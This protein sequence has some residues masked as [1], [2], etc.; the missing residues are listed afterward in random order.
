MKKNILE[1]F[2]DDNNQLME[3][4]TISTKIMKRL[5][6]F[7]ICSICY[8][9]LTISKNYNTIYTDEVGNTNTTEYINIIML[10][11]YIISAI[12]LIYLILE[13]VIPTK[14]KKITD[15]L[16]FNVKKKI[17]TVLDWLL[18]LPI[19]CNIAVGIYSHLFIITPISG[20]SMN[21]TIENKGN[22]LISY[23]DK[24]DRFD[25]VVAK[26]TK[27]D[28]LGSITNDSYY[29]KRV[30]GL[31]GDKVTWNWSTHTLII[32]GEK[33]DESYFPTNYYEDML[34]SIKQKYSYYGD[35]YLERE[36]NRINLNESF[37]GTFKYKKYNE[38]TNEYEIVET[39]IIPEGYYF[40]MGDNRNYN[41]SYDSRR[42]GLVPKKN[43]IGVAKYKV[44]VMIP[45][46][47]IK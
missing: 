23:L 25:V 26:I 5:I 39:T 24:V 17:F 38:I 11:C 9:L 32:N 8:P 3:R 15:K 28:N 46:E 37:D 6:G 20:T 40:I 2:F 19:C 22:V 43:I 13:L 44:A 31:P 7:I 34:N 41:G 42:I 29:I 30:I 27:E 12:G 1:K 45:Y 47:K 18:I 4:F 33:I 21:P 16:S 14:V 35:E 36:L 10:V